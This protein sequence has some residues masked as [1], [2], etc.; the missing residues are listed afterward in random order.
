MLVSPPQKK[1][2]GKWKAPLQIP[3][4]LAYLASAVP[5]EAVSI[6]D[7]EA[8][9]FTP[10][11]FTE[12]LRKNKFDLIGFTVVT[13]TVLVVLELARI[14][15]SVCPEAVVVCGGVHP[16]LMPEEI[17]GTGDV[18]LVVKGE[19]ENTFKEIVSRLK[20]GSKDF[21]GVP[22]V[23]FRVRGRLVETTDRALIEDLDAL[24][25]PAR[26]LL[27]N[28]SYTFPDTLYKSAFPIITSR[29]CPGFCNY[30]MSHKIHSRK[31]R[32]RSAVNVVDEIEILVKNF[33]AREIHIWDD[34]FA[35]DRARVFAIRDEL[36]RRKLKIK[37]AFPHGIRA[38]YLDD[39]MLSA[40]KEM[41]TYSLGIGVESGCQRILDRTGKGIDLSKVEE[42][43]GLARETGLE[44]WAFFVLGLP[45][46][47]AASIQESIDFAKKTDPDIVKFHILTPFPGSEIY[48]YLKQR[49]LILTHDY[50]QYSF[51]TPPVHRLEELE[52]SDLL[53]WQKKAY[54]SFYFRPKKIIQQIM[55]I[56]TLNR[57][58]V[59]LKAGFGMVRMVFGK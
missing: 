24:H 51:H 55:R 52:A 56:K 27:R 45:G 57:L 30:C 33:K 48:D 16:T 14:V 29:G 44:V 20:T 36:K 53:A 4:G 26:E 31:F 22:G 1:T 38:D 11:L 39:E 2:Y 41:G 35:T 9:K 46:E 47:N 37:I 12:F 6:L 7:M 58:I 17:L 28:K 3:L 10:E 15:K 54:R 21:S 42:V 8:D 32:A 13:P 5:D 40:L 49:D 59:N 43:I 34:N 25:Y 19:G 50:S 23:V 18:D